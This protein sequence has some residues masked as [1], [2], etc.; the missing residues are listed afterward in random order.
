MKR[1][2]KNL[3][4]MLVLAILFASIPITASLASGEIVIPVEEEVIIPVE[5]K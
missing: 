2:L 1:T 3:S 5:E 4:I